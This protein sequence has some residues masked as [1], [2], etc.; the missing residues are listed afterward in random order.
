MIDT[1]SARCLL[2][3]AVSAGLLLLTGLVASCDAYMNGRE[4]A[5]A[6]Q[7]RAREASEEGSAAPPAESR[8]QTTEQPDV[9]Y[10]EAHW[11]TWRQPDEAVDAALEAI[12]TAHAEGRSHALRRAAADHL[13]L[14]ANRPVDWNRLARAAYRAG[15]LY[16][17][18]YWARRRTGS[19]S[20]DNP[21]GHEHIGVM[22]DRFVARQI[23]HLR[24]GT[25]SCTAP[26]ASG[27]CR[28]R[29]P[30]ETFHLEGGTTV[31]FCLGPGRSNLIEVRRDGRRAL[32]PFAF[33][34]GREES[35][36]LLSATRAELL[37]NEGRELLVE[38]FVREGEWNPVCPPTGCRQRW[39]WRVRGIDLA[40]TSPPNP[41]IQVAVVDFSYRRWQ[42]MRPG[43]SD[44][45]IACVL[46]SSIESCQLT[47]RDLEDETE[48]LR[49]PDIEWRPEAG[50]V[51][52]DGNVHAA[53]AEPV[54]YPEA[55]SVPL[56]EPRHGSPTRCDI[57]PWDWSAADNAP[58]SDLH[59]I[60]EPDRDEKGPGVRD[61]LSSLPPE[62]IVHA[63][64]R[65]TSEDVESLG[66]AERS[67]RRLDALASSK[68]EEFESCLADATERLEFERPDSRSDDWLAAEPTPP[69]TLRHPFCRPEPSD[70]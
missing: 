40:I 24:E 65:V 13:G 61:C 64:F 10:A 43:F 11:N 38:G 15:H 35:V 48:A 19:E 67:R 46:Q 45:D 14:A 20:D 23:R 58:R 21:E 53:S 25:P 6:S 32:F 18:I 16:D 70:R 60:L 30:D 51:V 42:R 56:R 37:A 12:E 28:C 26:V 49:W 5:E 29:H 50:E 63:T 1:M 59:H 44:G 27:L 55:H 33:G 17:A 31:E 57:G 34:E 2:R 47:R 62:T 22:V 54:I 52:V 7:P 4:Q 69:Y 9:S 3:G 68:I 66:L 8:E 39:N 36:K 41:R